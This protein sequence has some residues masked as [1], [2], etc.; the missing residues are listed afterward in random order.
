MRFLFRCLAGGLA[1]TLIGCGGESMLPV[2]EAPELPL[3]NS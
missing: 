2:G 3:H 1:A